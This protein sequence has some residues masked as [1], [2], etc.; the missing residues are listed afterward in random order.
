M[1]KITEKLSHLCINTALGI[2]KISGFLKNSGPK[3]EVPPGPPLNGQRLGSCSIQNTKFL[4][5]R[6]STLEWFLVT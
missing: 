3:P 2:S 5:V 1:Q 6:R 4:T